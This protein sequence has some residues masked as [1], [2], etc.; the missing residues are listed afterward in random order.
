[1]EST[2]F[3]LCGLS[4]KGIPLGFKRY[5]PSSL[6]GYYGP[7][8]GDIDGGF[9]LDVATLTLMGCHSQE[10]AEML[11]RVHYEVND[12]EGQPVGILTEDF[13]EH[14]R[15]GYRSSTQ[16][17]SFPGLFD[18]P[19]AVDDD[20]LNH[21]VGKFESNRNDPRGIKKRRIMD[22]YPLYNTAVIY[23]DELRYA[24]WFQKRLRI[25]EVASRISGCRIA[26]REL[27]V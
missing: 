17:R 6:D 4:F 22:V 1:M 11:P 2:F 16:L 20:H 9:T 27:V 21:V 19:D 18:K 24:D 14:Q 26:G 3:S 10:W 15:L 5:R 12:D 7:E 8:F 25:E 23:G 13:S